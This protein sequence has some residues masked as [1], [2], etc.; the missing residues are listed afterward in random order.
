MGMLCESSSPLKAI[1]F[2]LSVATKKWGNLPANAYI[3]RQFF[4]QRT[5]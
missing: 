3:L 4:A 2:E 5:R 1:F